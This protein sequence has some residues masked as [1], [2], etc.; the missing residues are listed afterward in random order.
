MPAT[1]QKPRFTFLLTR[2]IHTDGERTY[3]GGQLVDSEDDLQKHNSRAVMR[4]VLAEDR[5][6]TEKETPHE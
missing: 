5:G 4:F 1:K 3:F 2:G 6:P